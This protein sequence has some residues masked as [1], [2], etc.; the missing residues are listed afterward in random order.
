MVE[1]SILFILNE[2]PKKEYDKRL[3]SLLKGQINKDVI[4]LGSSKGAGNILAEQLQSNTGFSSFNLSYQ[5]SNVNFHEFILETL[6]KYNKTPKYIILN[7]DDENQFVK[8][9]TLNFRDDILFPLTKYNYINEELITQRKAS[10][11]SRFLLL[12]RYN[13]Y[14]SIFRKVFEN[15]INPIDSFGSMGIINSKSSA[16]KF[17]VKKEDYNQEAEDVN[18]IESFKSIQDIC[19]LNDIE[20]LLVFSPRL[21]CFNLSFYN[22]FIKMVKREKNVIVYDTLNMVYKNPLYYRDPSHLLKNGAK[23]F[24]SEISEFINSNK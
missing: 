12:S 5:G 9:K 13:S 20:L 14:H 22:R 18:L 16:H 2:T 8:T 7:I 24:T 1:K 23:I 3:E 21:R 19:D 10:S 17:E 11:L 4:V 15:K 6:L